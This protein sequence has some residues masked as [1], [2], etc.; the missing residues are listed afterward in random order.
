MKG[1]KHARGQRA[2]NAVKH[3]IKPSCTKVAFII[4]Q[5]SAHGGHLQKRI[6]LLAQ[7]LT[8]R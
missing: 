4:P 6:S 5:F 1:R 8:S 2:K 3:V 7:L